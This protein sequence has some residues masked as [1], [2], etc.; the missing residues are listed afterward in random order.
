MTTMT[1]LR[2]MGALFLCTSAVACAA[3]DLEDDADLEE[4]GTQESAQAKQETP[5]KEGQG[6]T[7]TSKIRNTTVSNG[8]YTSNGSG[9]YKCCSS[10]GQ[11]QVC[12]NCDV[13]GTTSCSDKAKSGRTSTWVVAPF[14]TSFAVSP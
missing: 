6:C 9:G 4:V 3:G 7:A 5:S 11:N 12:I 14:A 13:P 10:P 8:T 1:W 2:T